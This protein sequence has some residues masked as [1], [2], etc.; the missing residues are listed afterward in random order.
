MLGDFDSTVSE[1]DMKDFCEIY[2][3][4]NLIK[5]PTCYKKCQTSVFY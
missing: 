3:L 4:H 5:E 1:T 2:D